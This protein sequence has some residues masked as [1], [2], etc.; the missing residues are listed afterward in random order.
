[1]DANG[2]PVRVAMQQCDNHFGIAFPTSTI[3]EV[4]APKAQM[5]IVEERSVEPVF[6]QT[7]CVI[8]PITYRVKE[9]MVAPADHVQRVNTNSGTAIAIQNESR[10]AIIGQKVDQAILDNTEVSQTFPIIRVLE[11]DSE[12]NETD[13]MDN[14]N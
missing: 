14:M 5:A 13:D 3:S 2:H 11:V 6:I 10:T 12:M 4:E 8:R 7:R 1:M 9:V